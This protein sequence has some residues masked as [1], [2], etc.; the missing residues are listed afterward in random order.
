MT[1]DGIVKMIWE[2][3]DG[4]DL[5]QPI[6]LNDVLEISFSYQCNHYCNEIYL[7]DVWNNYIVFKLLIEKIQNTR[8]TQAIFF[9]SIMYF[10]LRLRQK[11]E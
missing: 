3:G 2:T 6:D 7:H 5:V 1:N 4:S 8:V 11:I 9:S 10:W